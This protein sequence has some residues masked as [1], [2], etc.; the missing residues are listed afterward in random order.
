MDI[1]RSWLFR[2]EYLLLEVENLFTRRRDPGPF[3]LGEFCLPD[4]R[5][6]CSIIGR[7][8]R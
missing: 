8:S 3:I 4:P 7:H 5:S 1:V 6:A 2:K